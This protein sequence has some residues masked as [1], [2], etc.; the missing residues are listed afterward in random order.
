MQEQ[1]PTRP[2]VAAY[3][4]PAT[5]EAARRLDVLIKEIRE[6]HGLHDAHPRPDGRVELTLGDH[7]IIVL[8]QHHDYALHIRLH[9]RPIPVEPML[10]HGL[11]AALLVANLD[12]PASDRVGISWPGDCVIYQRCV[13]LHGLDS[14]GLHAALHE[15]LQ[16]AAEVD[17]HLPQAHVVPALAH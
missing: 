5:S 10:R 12:L 3:P 11:Y 4:H 2:P 1:Q 17:R 15:V 6:A 8:P 13:I 9:M 14:R 7:R 16:C